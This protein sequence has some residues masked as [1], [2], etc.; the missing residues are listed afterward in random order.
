VVTPRLASR[1]TAAL[2]ARREGILIERNN[3]E[4]VP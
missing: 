2:R 4:I 3:G 1:M